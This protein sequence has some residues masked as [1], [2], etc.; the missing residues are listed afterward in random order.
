MNWGSSR[1]ELEVYV[2]KYIYLSKGFK[3]LSAPVGNLSTKKKGQKMA[4]FRKNSKGRWEV[5]ISLTIDDNLLTQ[6][7]Q[8][9]REQGTSRAAL[10]AQGMHYVVKRGIWK[11]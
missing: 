8:L 11:D 9:A 1:G 3:Y 5:Q 2:F 6:I 10:I 7:D 4:S